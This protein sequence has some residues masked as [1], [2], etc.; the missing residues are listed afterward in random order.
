MAILRHE[1]LIIPR[2]KI[3]EGIDRCKKNIADLLEDARLIMETE[4]LGEAERLGHAYI[5]VQFALEELGKILVL[6][7]K[8]KKDLNDDPLKFLKKGHH[9]G[10]YDHWTKTNEAR[11]F[12]GHDF[13]KIYDEGIIQPGIAVKGLFQEDTFVDPDTRLECAFVD[14]YA[15]DWKLGRDIKK[16]LLVKLICRIEEKLPDA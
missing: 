13:D 14:W 4:R 11:D 6:R 5:S 9:D 7:D 2:A 8:L 1:D 10:F 15:D 12:I 16:D 3:P